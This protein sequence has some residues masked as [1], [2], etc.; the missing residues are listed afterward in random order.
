MLVLL[1]DSLVGIADISL[2]SPGLHN[3]VQPNVEVEEFTS[4]GL[5][6]CGRVLARA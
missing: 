4:Q 2:P 5:R 1:T 3:I 6:V